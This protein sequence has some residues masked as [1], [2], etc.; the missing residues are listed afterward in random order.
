VQKN[1]GN[2]TID[3]DGNG[4]WDLTYN[5]MNGLTSSYQA[6]EKTPGFEIVLIVFVISAIA[7]VMYWKRKRK[8]K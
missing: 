8:R 7:L 1:D 2:Y 5:A 3:S 4:E 6:Q